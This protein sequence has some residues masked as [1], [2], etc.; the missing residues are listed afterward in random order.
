MS[1]EEIRG[2]LGIW[3]FPI[4]N[5]L[6]KLLK[7]IREERFGS[8]G[9]VASATQRV[10]TKNVA[11]NIETWEWVDYKGIPRKVT[12]KRHVEYRGE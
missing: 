12:V 6:R 11:E 3:A 8:F 5:F 7:K 9:S 2:P 10:R 1:S 4:L